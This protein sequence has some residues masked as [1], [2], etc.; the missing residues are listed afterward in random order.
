MVFDDFKRF[1]ENQKES[2]E[3]LKVVKGNL[4]CK[5]SNLQAKIPKNELQ[6]VLVAEMNSIERFYRNLRGNI[7]F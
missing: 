6:R 4:K 2:L 5:N 3:G 1:L 7:K